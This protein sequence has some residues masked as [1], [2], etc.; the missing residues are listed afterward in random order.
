MAFSKSYPKT[1]EGFNYP[2]WEEVYLDEEEE[3]LTEKQARND[4]IAL[5]KECIDDAKKI[6]QDKQL[7]DFQSDVIHIAIALFEKRSSHAIYYKEN[8]TKE[9]F[10]KS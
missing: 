3:L 9:K 7:K 10:H 5:M 4:N 6:V 8:K 1:I 2:K